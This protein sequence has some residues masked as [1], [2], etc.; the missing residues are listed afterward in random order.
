MIPWMLL[1]FHYRNICLLLT[2]SIKIQNDKI[3]Q[4][5]NMRNPLNK[6]LFFTLMLVFQMRFI[7][8]ARIETSLTSKFEQ[9]F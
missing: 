5:E 8:K 4:D 2:F 7:A 6:H 9:N 3:N 1:I